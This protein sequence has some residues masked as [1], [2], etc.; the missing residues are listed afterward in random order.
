V[1]APL[2]EKPAAQPPPKKRP[3][4]QPPPKKEPT[5]KTYWVKFQ[6]KEVKPWPV[7]VAEKEKDVEGVNI[8]V[9][10]PGK[11]KADLGNSE[12]TTKQDEPV[13]FFD[14]AEQGTCEI[15]GLTHPNETWD[16]IKVE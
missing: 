4:P 8:K 16:V 12:G 9:N 13:A 15:I 2:P 5:K 1:E 7:P 3:L 6:V 11:P 14:I 10:I